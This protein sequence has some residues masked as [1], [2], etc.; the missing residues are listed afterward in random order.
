MPCLVWTTIELIGRA[1]PTGLPFDDIRDLLTRLPAADAEA[2]AMVRARDIE[3]TKPPGSLGRL[4]TLVEW[5]AAWQGRGEP[6]LARPLVAVFAGNHG[7]VAKGVSPY[8]AS[9]TSAMVANFSAGG[10][11][12]NQICAAFGLG[13]KVFELALDIPT[14]DI[15]E[16]AAL[17]E[18]ECAATMAFGME[19]VADG[20]DLLA[21]GEMGIG[22]TTIAAAIYHGLYGGSAADWVGR[23]TGVDDAGL[24]RKIAAV[25]AAVSRHRAHLGDP[26]ELLRRLGGREVAA[27]AGAILAARMQRVP[28]VLDGYVVCAAAAVLH[29][30]DPGSIDHCLA[31]HVSAEGAH[32]EVLRHL[33][34]PP[35]LDLGMRLG[36]GSGAAL[37]IG[38]V[39]AALACHSGMA[40]FAEAGV[41]NKA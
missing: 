31:G 20:V 1:M 10:A 18:K 34:K 2:V 24:A 6:T 32:R 19:A 12:I 40:T 28:V 9:V 15:T 11:A 39:K 17:D 22:N 36:E 5:L 41:A 35:L 3:L 37:A 23:G 29:R 4:E 33:G 25:E 21:L 27:M 30:L 26:L 38:I 16:Q 13:L 14:A 8:P 7:V